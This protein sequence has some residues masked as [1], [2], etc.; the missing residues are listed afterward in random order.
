MAPLEGGATDLETTGSDTLGADA[1]ISYGLKDKSY[2]YSFYK[3]H[4]KCAN[5][6]GAADNTKSNSAGSVMAWTL[7]K[8]RRIKPCLIRH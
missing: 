8:A 3:S 7:I 6:L 5:P 1:V 4:E 2:S